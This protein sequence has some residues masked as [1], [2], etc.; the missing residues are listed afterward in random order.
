MNSY[1]CQSPFQTC[2]E[3]CLHHLISFLLL[4][5]RVKFVEKIREGKA[6]HT[7][8][9]V[10]CME[11]GVLYLRP[12]SRYYRFF[13]AKNMSTRLRQNLSFLSFRS[14]FIVHI[15]R[16]LVPSIIITDTMTC[17]AHLVLSSTVVV[18]RTVMIP[19]LTTRN[20]HWQ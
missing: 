11:G 18:D 20:Y 8:M 9:C 16:F 12:R 14:R 6:K 1:T 3:W 17:I 19:P 15:S 10:V 13:G 7:L 5:T 4:D 2:F